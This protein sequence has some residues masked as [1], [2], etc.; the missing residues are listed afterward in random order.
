LLKLSRPLHLILAALTYLLGAS[1]PTYLAKPFHTTAFWLGLVGVLC[2][3]LS[4]NLLAEAFRP[5]NEPL[6]ANETPG[7]KEALR[8]NLLYISY[9]SFAA[10]L[11]TAF[12]LFLNHSLAVPTFYFFLLSLL[13][14][15]TYAIPPF[16]LL[17]RGFG[18]LALSAH[19]A[20]IIP[21][22]GFLLQ[23][24]ETHRL[25]LIMTVPL[26]ALALAYFLV[27]DFPTFVNDQKYHRATLLRTLG[28][29][30]AVP[31][32]HSLIIFAY[33]FFAMVP[34]FGLSFSLIS[35]AFISLPF[36]VFQ[37]LQ[38]R[39]IAH[40]RKPNWPLLT[41]NAFAVFALTTYFLLLTFWTG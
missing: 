39:A 19:I 41:V 32:H 13:L 20:Y 23:A 24:A 26:T 29:E 18:E 25:L 3:Q 6:I 7:Q 8:N 31:L 15:L 9:A 12:I 40:G 27:L 14:I 11:L 21:S 2:A 34:L 17:D 30:T 5:H 28:W 36:A 37:I 35:R 4:M 22:I 33:A 16:R 1:I 38:L 10:S